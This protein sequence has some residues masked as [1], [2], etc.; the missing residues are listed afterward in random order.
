[1]RL[2]PVLSI[3]LT[4]KPRDTMCSDSCQNL[5]SSCT[6]KTAVPSPNGWIKRTLGAVLWPQLPARSFV[7]GDGGEKRRSFL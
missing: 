4:V 2:Y 6:V 1:M 3:L 7:S 5:G